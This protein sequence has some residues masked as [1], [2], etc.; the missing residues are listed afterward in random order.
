MIL[1]FQ[2]LNRST[3]CL[4]GLGTWRRPRIGIIGAQIMIINCINKGL[5]WIELCR[6]AQFIEN[7]KV[8]IFKIS[9]FTPFKTRVMDIAKLYKQ[10]ELLI[11]Q[12]CIHIWLTCRLRTWACTK[13]KDLSL[14]CLHRNFYLLILHLHIS[15]LGH[16]L[17]LHIYLLAPCGHLYHHRYPLSMHLLL[18]N[19]RTFRMITSIFNNIVT[20]LLENHVNL[21]YLSLILKIHQF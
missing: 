4:S 18:S 10:I 3:K 9:L 6:S 11:S 14:F 15:I 17:Q 13:L 1:I 19:S 20:F 21:Q 5:L 2:L 8:C 12:C 16:H 7:L